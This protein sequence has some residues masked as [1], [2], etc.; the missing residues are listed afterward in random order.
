MKTIVI[1]KSK[2]G[3]TKKYAEW[4]A[5]ALGC[6]AKTM[7]QFNKYMLND[8]DQVIYGG[9]IMAGNINGLKKMKKYCAEKK[10][11]LI[12][13]A[14]GATPAEAVEIVERIR[15]TNLTKEEQ[16]E[17]PFYYYGA[18]INYEK[19]SGFPKFMLHMM[20]K[21]LSKKKNPT[22]EEKGMAEILAH[23]CDFTNQKSIEALVE[24]FKNCEV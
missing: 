3:F 16:N 7:D 8:V 15:D 14:T 18:G 23:S 24:R 2:T 21:Q 10:K 6:E 4:I 20:S 1:Y 5:A 11:K 22:E 13:F 12:V 17:I 19:M 9:G